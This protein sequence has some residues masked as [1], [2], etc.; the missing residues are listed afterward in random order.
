MSSRNLKDILDKLNAEPTYRNAFFEDPKS[1][2]ERELPGM[3]VDDRLN[4]EI[5]QY[6]ADIRDRISGPNVTF[7]PP[8]EGEEVNCLFW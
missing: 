2:L 1:F 4:N 8:E 3:T 7:R 6:Y 5:K